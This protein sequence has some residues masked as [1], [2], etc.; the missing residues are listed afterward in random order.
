MVPSA[1]SPLFSACFGIAVGGLVR[2]KYA[3][4]GTGFIAGGV[5]IGMA[6][7]IAKYTSPAASASMQTAA[8]AEAQGAEA[9]AMAGF[10]LGRAFAPGLGG[11]GSL[12]Q[13]RI[14]DSSMLFGVG[15]PDMSASRMFNGATVSVEEGGQMSG[16][17]VSIETPSNFAGAL[18]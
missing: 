6:A 8:A 17:S 15:T 10:G 13:A 1:W 5:G 18:Q 9:Q 3:A 4:I 16:A 12:G 7:L 11:L 14:Q 2:S